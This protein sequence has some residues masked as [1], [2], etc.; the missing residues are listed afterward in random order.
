M[1][2]VRYQIVVVFMLAAAVAVTSVIVA[3]W[4]RRTFFTPAERLVARVPV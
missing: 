1:K 2:A 4:Y 3:L